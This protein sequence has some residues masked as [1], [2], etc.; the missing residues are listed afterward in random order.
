MTAYVSATTMASDS[1]EWNL[2][3]FLANSIA[4][5]LVFETIYFVG[6]NFFVFTLAESLGLTQRFSE[7]GDWAGN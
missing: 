2:F 1:W 4:V 5:L 7:L 3:L 6:K